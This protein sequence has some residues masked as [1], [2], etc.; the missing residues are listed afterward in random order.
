MNA[1]LNS[2]RNDVDEDIIKI[3]KRRQKEKKENKLRLGE[4]Y[5]NKNN[6]I[7]CFNA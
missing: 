5:N 3:L 1:Q 7:F 6:L 4:K 2:N